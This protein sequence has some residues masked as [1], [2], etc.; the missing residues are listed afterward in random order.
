MENIWVVERYHALEEF[1]GE[2]RENHL[3]RILELLSLDL[4]MAREI[5]NTAEIDRGYKSGYNAIQT[6]SGAL[7]SGTVNSGSGAIGWMLLVKIDLLVEV[8]QDILMVL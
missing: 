6:S 2:I 8:D 7:G 5:S 3:V 4:Q 1:I